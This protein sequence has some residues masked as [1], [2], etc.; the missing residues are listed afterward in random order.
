MALL[1]DAH[2]VVLFRLYKIKISSYMS[3]KGLQLR[4]VDSVSLL[5]IGSSLPRTPNKSQ[6]PK[7][8]EVAGIDVT[9]KFEP[10]EHRNDIFSLGFWDKTVRTYQ[11]DAFFLRTA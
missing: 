9:S 5:A 7:G 10:F 8:D 4:G 3:I 1:A 2:G 11:E 6:Y